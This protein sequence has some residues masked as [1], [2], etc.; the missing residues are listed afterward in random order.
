MIRSLLNRRMGGPTVALIVT[1]MLAGAAGIASAQDRRDDRDR[2]RAYEQR[3]E[4]RPRMPARGTVIRVLPREY[5]RVVVRGVPYLFWGGVFYRSGPTGYVVVAAPFGAV[6]GVLPAGYVAVRLG[7]ARYFYY[8]GVFY[9]PYGPQYTVV[10][11]PM[12]AEVPYV[13]EGYAVADINGLLYYQYD[14]VYYLPT[15]RNGVV[16]YIVSRP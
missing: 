14:G 11:P 6:V 1:A 4:A 5:T 15:V 13:P 7:P 3:R 8:G 10:T 2:P 12:G 16:S 9:Q